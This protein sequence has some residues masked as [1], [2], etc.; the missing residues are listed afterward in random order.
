MKESAELA[1]ASE[2]LLV[3][4]PMAAAIGI[5]VDVSKPEG[6]MI[7]DIGGSTTRDY[8]ISL[9][10]IGTKESILVAGDEQTKSILDWFGNRINLELVKELLKI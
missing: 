3:E 6:N 7:V 5:G 8:V 2:V 10:G 1:N 4:E 9:N